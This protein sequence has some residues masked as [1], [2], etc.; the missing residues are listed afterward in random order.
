MDALTMLV[1]GQQTP[2]V[3]LKITGNPLYYEQPNL[4]GDVRT[5]T[6]HAQC[7]SKF[8]VRGLPSGATAEVF[9][10]PYNVECAYCFENFN[11]GPPAWML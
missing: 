8:Y 5:V 3:W 11:P 4:G 1:L 2:A 10:P 6:M 7:A 9:V